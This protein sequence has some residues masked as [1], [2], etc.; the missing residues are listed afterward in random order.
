MA[1][2]AESNTRALPTER[3][4]VIRPIPS[5]APVTITTTTVTTTT[6]DA[7][8]STVCP[9]CGH[10]A[11]AAEVRACRGCYRLFT[12]THG[13][14]QFFARIHARDGLPL[15]PPTHCASCRRERR[16]I[17]RGKMSS[18][19]SKAARS[20]VGAVAVAADARA[21]VSGVSGTAHVGTAAAAA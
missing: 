9:T 21:V 17:R 20:E 19:V 4:V 15:S 16:R 3:P 6:S 11:A 10:D 8:A 7:K 5:R 13:E 18:N 1:A 2:R 14:L 12:L